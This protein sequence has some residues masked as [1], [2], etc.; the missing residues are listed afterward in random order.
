M[1]DYYFFIKKVLIRPKTLCTAPGSM[2]LDVIHVGFLALHL[3]ADGE[4]T[5]SNT[6][7]FA[8]LRTTLRLCCYSKY[9]EFYLFS[10]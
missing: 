2:R 3:A 5:D 6:Q 8:K 1:G 9:L 4:F 7:R 10:F